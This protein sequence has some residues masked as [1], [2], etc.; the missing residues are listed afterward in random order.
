M[1]SDL[2][3]NLNLV[4]LNLDELYLKFIKGVDE[5]R[6]FVNVAFRRLE[7]REKNVGKLRAIIKNSGMVMSEPQESRISVFHRILGLPVVSTL[8]AMNNSQFYSPGFDPDAKEGKKTNVISSMDESLS[9]LFS[10][11]EN[12]YGGQ[13]KSAFMDNKS[14]ATGILCMQSAML[15]KDYKLI[16]GLTDTDLFKFAYDLPTRD[17]QNILF[18][19]YTDANG[20][21]LSDLGK[22]LSTG[23]YH[24]P[25]PFV[26]DGRY[27]VAPFPAEKQIC[28]PFLDDSKRKY[29]KD[30]FLLRPAIELILKE[31]TAA[32]INANTSSAND[33][34]QVLKD[35]VSEWQKAGQANDINT[36]VM[37]SIFANGSRVAPKFI[38]CLVSLATELADLQKTLMDS[39]NK[40]RGYYYLPKPSVQGPEYGCGFTGIMTYDPNRLSSTLE[41]SIRDADIKA[42]LQRMADAI[43]SK[44]AEKGKDLDPTQYVFGG[45]TSSFVNAAGNGIQSRADRDLSNA[46][47][48]RKET[49]TKACR[50]I[51]RIE[52]ITGEFSGLGL[53]DV[54][55]ALFAL[56]TVD[57]SSLCGLI[58]GDAYAR[59][60]LNSNIGDPGRDSIN[61]ALQ[62][63]DDTL[64]FIYSLF[65]KLYQEK[66]GAG[67]KAQPQTGTFSGSGQN[68]QTTR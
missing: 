1:A 50:A 67:I 11:R 7:F 15:Q 21:T 57:L 20:K 5:Y 28:A 18:T 62:K 40:V 48:V 19:K 54:V 6:S 53:I 30:I 35:Q 10:V 29:N 51:Q 65:D 44:T 43:T 47:A 13:I 17:L 66:L 41:S 22:T 61:V 52:I 39:R 3:G 31:R 16:I 60:M 9:K 38:S 59:A 8:T 36:S 32:G 24:F 14:L 26:V 37:S 49:L 23:A 12:Y 2:Y 45:Q 25:K 58:D 27:D 68:S 33:Q 63:F 64:K 42:S 55:A 4:D 46:I 56:Y 34:Y